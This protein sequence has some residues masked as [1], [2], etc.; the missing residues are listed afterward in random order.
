MCILRTLTA[1]LACSSAIGGSAS[2]FAQ[3]RAGGGATN[4]PSVRV[5]VQ[6]CRG[7]STWRLTTWVHGY[8]VMSYAALGA[9]P[10]LNGYSHVRGG[11]FPTA[12]VPNTKRGSIIP[13]RA[14]SH[15]KH[16]GAISLVFRNVIPPHEGIPGEGWITA[17]GV[18]ECGPQILLVDMDPFP[19]NIPQPKAPP[20][21]IPKV[22]P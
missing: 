13:W 15:W 1:V 7:H 18:M 21:R 12:H 14:Y 9:S 4:T 10:N 19:H 20:L 16:F 17:H 5:L 2:A 3:P 8:F 6:T 22:K 11:L